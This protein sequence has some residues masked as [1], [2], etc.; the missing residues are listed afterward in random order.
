MAAA[1][2]PAQAQTA[3][4]VRRVVA[5]IS[6]ITGMSVKR[7]VPFETIS[8][9]GWK[10]WVDQ[11]IAENAKPEEIRAEELALKK[12]GLIPRDFDLRQAT[13]D[14]LG[15]QAAAVYDHRKK[16]MLFVEGGS[17]SAG[18]MGDMVLV[19]ELAHALAD[20]HYDLGKFIDKAPGSDE[21]QTARMAVVEG[22]AMWIM[23]ESQMKRMGT[24]LEQN[25]GMLDVFSTSMTANIKGLFPV[26]DSAP[27]YMRQTLMFPYLAGLRFQQKAISQYGKKG[28]S[29]VLRRPPSTTREVLHPD[30]WL[31]GIAPVKTTLPALPRH[32]SFKSIT[33]GTVGELD[34][35]ILF[36]QFVTEADALE[37]APKWRGGSFDLSEHDSGSHAVLRWSAAWENPQAAASAFRLYRKVLEGKWNTFKV[38]KNTP[39][40]LEGQ[41][42]DGDF[43]VTLAGP[44]VSSVEGLKP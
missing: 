8:R 44:V 16:R 29:E 38:T 41:G 40:V 22:Q 25:G 42:D 7:E 15:E 35:Q 14:L 6:E 13:V 5:T 4:D 18:M 1:L 17:A 34:F 23:L 28:F 10:Q 11:Q 19:H 2:L 43:R 24:S 32:K 9:E 37:L 21:S 3:E 26:F 30:L 27:L 33:K 36:T 20:Q 12:F 39:E 31:S